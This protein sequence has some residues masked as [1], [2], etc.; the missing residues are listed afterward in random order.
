MFVY[1]VPV[2]ENSYIVVVGYIPCTIFHQNARIFKQLFLNIINA[3][4]D[5]NII[6]AIQA[7]CIPTNPLNKLFYMLGSEQ[8]QRI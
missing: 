6:C 7:I 2:Y 1:I 5:L 8:Y 3:F 4:K